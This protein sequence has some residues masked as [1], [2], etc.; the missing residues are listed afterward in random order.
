MRS[1][2]LWY[3]LN[4][5]DC[6]QNKEVKVHINLWGRGRGVNKEY[7]FDFGLLV[8][9]ITD[10]DNIYLYCPFLLDRNQIQDLGSTIS[11]D[12]NLLNAIFNENLTTTVGDPKRLIVNSDLAEL[13]FI[14][15]SL[16]INKQINLDCKITSKIKRPGTILSIKFD[17]IGC[18]DLK[19]HYF[20]IR[21]NVPNKDI[22][23]INNQVKGT[24]IF[25]SY[26]TNTENIDF[27]LNDFRSCSEE[28]KEQFNK[29]QK[30]GITAIHY[31]IFRNANDVIIHHGKEMNSRMLEADLWDTYIDGLD[32][33]IIA[34]HLKSKAEVEPNGNLRYVKDFS[35]LTR[36]QYQEDTTAIIRKYILGIIA[37]GSIASIIGNGLTALVEKLFK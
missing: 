15:Y 32:Y 21:I 19:R 6:A 29:G 14:I 7:C 30:F 22:H 28:L 11:H 25:S 33:Y 13:N 24:S 4:N 18:K 20:R 27:R 8:E 16:E 35:A 5:K 10:I 26:F 34:Y 17:D 2:A 37:L 1:F 23:L 9:D 3:S 12:N 36:F 31:F